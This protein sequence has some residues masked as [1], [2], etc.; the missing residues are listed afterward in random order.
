MKK[1]LLTVT[2]LM[3]LVVSMVAVAIEVEV[4]SNFRWDLPI[5]PDVKPEYKLKMGYLDNP[6]AW[7]HG[8]HGMAVVFKNIVE[9]GTDG[10]VLVELY[11]SSQLGSESSMAQML[12]SGIAMQGAFLSEGIIPTFY[13][14]I[15]CLS[16][17]WLFKNEL[18][19]YRVMDGEFG[20]ELTA[21]MLKK[22]GVRIIG[23]G[24]NGGY[25]H[26]TNSKRPIHKP[27]DMK[28]LKIR[29]MEH[30][31][32]MAIMNSL[33]ASAT[34]MGWSDLYT[35]LQTGVVDGQ[36]N[37]LS[38]IN[39]GDLY[40]VQKYLT[41]DGHVYSID[42]VLIN[43]KW[44]QS[45]PEEYQRIIRQAGMLAGLHERGINKLTEWE[46]LTVIQNSKNV[47]EVYML[48]DAEKAEF[49]AI[50]QPAYLEWYH[51]SVDP[52]GI[53]SG[54]VLKAV[55]EAEAYYNEYFSK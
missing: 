7:L 2:F 26:I 11:P 21:D 40:Q 41:L 50:S 22:T 19:A 35:S 37:S 34:P 49:A 6:N 47:E 46:H 23:V 43:D 20:D 45:L 13:P 16:I 24:E 44:L 29:T 54:K 3:V 32:H 27:E 5:F 53:W 55:E 4:P 1:S 9:R 15:Q 18:I 36:E 38:L 31:G 8:E 48:S 51:K 39:N 25:R 33:G 10:K 14:E 17:P 28:G 12:R 42:F 52:E 30:A